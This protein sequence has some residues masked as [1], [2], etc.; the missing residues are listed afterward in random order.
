MPIDLIEINVPSSARPELGLHYRR[1]VPLRGQG[2]NAEL[3]RL[4][5]VTDLPS[6]G[7]LPAAEA[8]LWCVRA[9]ASLL[10]E[11]DHDDRVFVVRSGSLKCVKTLEDGYEQVLAFARGLEGR[12]LL[13]EKILGRAAKSRRQNRFAEGTRQAVGA[14]RRRGWLSR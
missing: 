12:D 2:S 7:A 8:D 9:G 10:R 13:D 11:G 4:L 3:L 5:G 14:R 6:R 1:V